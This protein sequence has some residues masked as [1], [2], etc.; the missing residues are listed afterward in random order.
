ML[1]WIIIITIIKKAAPAAST[2]VMA[3]RVLMGVGDI[4]VFDGVVANG[5]DV[6][7]GAD[8]R[9]ASRGPGI[10]MMVMASSFLMV[11][12]SLPAARPAP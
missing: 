6:L 4:D 2:L 7:D 3:M 9:T 5:D 8:G 12:M 1:T 11:T 10:L